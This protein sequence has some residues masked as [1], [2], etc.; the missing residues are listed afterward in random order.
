MASELPVI[1]C[2][3]CGK[4]CETQT[5]PPGYCGQEFVIFATP[6]DE[7]RFYS[8]PQKAQDL[9]WAW[10][11]RV[12]SLNM[13]DELPHDEPC[14]WFNQETKRCQ[15]YEWRPSVCRD[16]EVGGKYCL[17]WRERVDVTEAEK[18]RDQRETRDGN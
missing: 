15:L 18:R 10:E 11:E 5:A 9:V 7:Q 6:E 13:G 14:C 17:Q 3:G 12:E 8:A 1:S 2:D 4:C 16:F